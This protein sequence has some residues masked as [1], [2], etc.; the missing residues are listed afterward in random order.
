VDK[1]QVRPNAL[2][3]LLSEIL[4]EEIP[5]AEA[6]VGHAYITPE[7]H[8]KSP[9]PPP[10]IF[11]SYDWYITERY[12]HGAL[13]QEVPEYSEYHTPFSYLRTLVPALFADYLD[14]DYLIHWIREFEGSG[15]YLVGE[16]GSGKTTF[17][18]ACLSHFRRTWTTPRVHTLY[19][20]L[21][22]TEVTPGSPPSE[23]RAA[24]VSILR[25]QVA[26]PIYDPSVPERPAGLCPAF[27]QSDPLFVR[28]LVA[29][30]GE[31]WQDI[32]PATAWR[33]LTS[34]QM[35]SFEMRYLRQFTGGEKILVVLD[36]LDRYTVSEQVAAILLGK[37]LTVDTGASVIVTARP[38]SALRGALR[39]AFKGGMVNPGIA[40]TPPRLSRVLVSISERVLR[41]AKERIKT[42]MG[43]A[44]K[45]EFRA[46]HAA[47]TES[48]IVLEQSTTRA[49]ISV[50]VTDVTRAVK[51]LID[52]ATTPDVERFLFII[53]S[54][55][56]RIAMLKSKEYLKSGFLNWPLVF[57]KLHERGTVPRLPFHLFLRSYVS[58]SC[59]MYISRDQDP[60][61][62]ANVLTND[63][64]GY[65][66][67]ALV[68]LKIL[69]HLSRPGTAIAAVDLDGWGDA[70]RSQR[71]H[72]VHAV[73]ELVDKDIL[74]SSIGAQSKDLVLKKFDGEFHL[75]RSGKCFLQEVAGTLEYLTPIKYDIELPENVVS[76]W[77]PMEEANAIGVRAL[78]AVALLSYL[79]SVEQRLR[80]AQDESCP[81]LLL[82]LLQYESIPFVAVKL[83]SDLRTI[84]RRIGGNG[85]VER[86]GE[87]AGRDAQLYALQEAIRWLA[88]VEQSTGGVQQSTPEPQPSAPLT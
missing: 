59:R 65:M 56:I 49:Q 43:R 86:D 3:R 82:G 57:Y 29:Q 80:D 87:A 39:A 48:R 78:N 24:L 83:M 12:E 5:E 71:E 77:D 42:E 36:N 25:D 63:G 55:N 66:C 88:Q 81:P 46:L 35:L 75:R 60:L 68:R 85:R 58:R 50:R 52:S 69:V 51:R 31:K 84:A 16:V 74:I 79:K 15:L 45:K 2:N 4:E 76:L 13:C 19:A 27:A 26:I 17:V 30:G 20:N 1:Y 44:V 21:N 54:G 23:L 6:Q 62:V 37:R 67:K 28:E 10:R 8:W 72:V 64:Y 40:L 41:R 73:A 38:S 7:G 9:A 53:T 32:D 61:S 33:S 34:Y 22:A 18:L 14:E 70:Y 11:Q 47:A